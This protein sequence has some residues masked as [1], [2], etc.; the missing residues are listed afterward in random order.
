MPARLPPEPSPPPQAAPA[1][2]A[3]IRTARTTHITSIITVAAT[4]VVVT[5]APQLPPEIFGLAAG[6]IASQ[7]FEPQYA[8]PPPPPYGYSL[9]Q[10]REWCAATYRTYNWRYDVWTDYQGAPHAC[11]GPY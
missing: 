1:P 9:E 5:A 7:A 10:H 6:L 11:V 2:T 8:P 4:V 3:T